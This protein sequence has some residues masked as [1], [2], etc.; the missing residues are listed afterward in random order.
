VKRASGGCG[1]GWS[2]HAF[3][4]AVDLTVDGILDAHGDNCIHRPLLDI[5]PYMY[6]QKLYWGAGFSS[7]DAMHFEVSKQLAQEW[8]ANGVPA[9]GGTTPTDAHAVPMSALEPGSVPSAGGSGS[10]PGTCQN[11]H[12]DSCAT[13]Y[14][15]GLCPGSSS[16]KCCVSSNN[17]QGPAPAAA[18]G[19]PPC[20][21]HTHSGACITTTACSAMGGSSFRSSSG[22]NGC[23]SFANN[24]RCCILSG[25]LFVDE[26]P[27]AVSSLG[28]SA[29]ALPVGAIAGIVIGVI[30]LI[31]V[32]VVVVFFALRRARNADR[33]GSSIG[34]SNASYDAAAQ[35]VPSAPGS[36]KFI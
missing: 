8:M 14:L 15:T 9:L 27:D 29:F 35:D 34:V 11:I 16:I 21:Y 31:A 36:A 32:S 3:G 20:S 22:A 5:A 7:E 24:V 26:I 4:S 23:E 10:C 25:S 2:N 28:G 19:G 18:Q 33:S 30:V 13:D 1:S 6:A 12:T 17:D